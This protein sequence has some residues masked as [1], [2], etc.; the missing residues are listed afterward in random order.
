MSNNF[1]SSISLM[2]CERVSLKKLSY[3][4][5]LVKL[6]YSNPN[7]INHFT[8]EKKK[9]KK[10]RPPI[11]KLNLSSRSVKSAH[12]ARTRHISRKIHTSHALAHRN[13]IVIIPRVLTRAAVY[14][15]NHYAGVC[16]I[17]RKSTRRVGFNKAR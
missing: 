14:F 17:A 12:T 10:Y 8:L 1:I 13:K 11:L 6:K 5:P 2:L 15:N 7:K 9:K 16:I 4:V 3:I